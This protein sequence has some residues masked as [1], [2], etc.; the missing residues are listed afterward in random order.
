MNPVAIRA[1]RA[2]AGVAGLSSW[3]R[4]LVAIVAGAFLALALPPVSFVVAVPV[5]FTLLLWL[6]EGALAGG[7]PGRAAL[8]LGWCFGFGFFVAGLY[9]IAIAL[10]VDAARFGWLAPIAVV[11]LSAYFAFFPALAVL[12]ASWA[13]PGFGRIAVLAAAWGFAEMLRGSLLT[14]F[15]WNP[16]GSVLVPWPVFAQGAAYLGVFGLSVVVVFIGAGV[17][18]IAGADAG[19]GRWHLPAVAMVLIAMVWGG[20]FLRLQ[21]AP[22]LGAAAPGAPYIRIVQAAID[23]KIKWRPNLAR[24]HFMDY[25]T[26][27]RGAPPAPGTQTPPPVAVI[28]PETAVPAVFKGSKAYLRALAQAVPPGGILVT[29]VV[30]RTLGNDS[31]RTPENDSRGL[32]NS[33]L[34]IDGRGAL[35]AR[36]D[37]HHLVPFGEYVPLARFNPLPKLTEGRVDFSAGPGAR[38]L[39]LPGLGRVSPLVCYEVIF[40]GQVTAVAGPR[41]NVLLNLTNDA[42]F[43][44]STGPY[45][46]LASARLRAVEEGLPLVRAANTGISA[47]IDPYG[48]VIRR[49]ALGERGVLDVA[50][51]APLSAPTFYARMGNWPFLVLAVLLLGVGFGPF[52][53]G[54]GCP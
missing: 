18:M 3:S 30:R 17:M 44:M 38:T 39:S 11:G 48:R 1:D 52:R 32:W 16:M 36:Y 5:S 7:R 19:R 25:V 31:R 41:P 33:V 47:V 53:R 54:Q 28:W 8:A 49:L 29:G 2:A 24:Q 6:L 42:W 21:G 43:G 40:P 14:G 37:K 13:R 45:Q 51:P 4:A 27:S 10:L 15:P 12:A 23:Q 26:L 35:L 50:V 20:G 22:V 9:W 34:A 46:H